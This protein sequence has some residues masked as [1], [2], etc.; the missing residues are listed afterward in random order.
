MPGEFEERHARYWAGKG[1]ASDDKA[2]FGTDCDRIMYS[3]AFRR[4]DGVTQ[5]VSSDETAMFHNRLTHSLKV[6]E[7]GARITYR[8]L[9]LMEDSRVK[10]IV[11]DH[12]G[13]DPRVVRAACL[14]HD[15]GH[16]PFGHIGEHELQRV[17]TDPATPHRLADSFEGNAQTFRIVTRLAFREPSGKI[18]SDA[19]DLTRATLRALLKYSWTKNE[20]L[21]HENEALEEKRKEKW[22]AYDSE[23]E[24]F[25]WARGEPAARH[26]NLHDELRYEYRSIEAQIMDWADDIT[27]AV[28]D[29]E[30]FFRA[31][32]IPLHLLRHSDSEFKIF[33]DRAWPRI[34]KQLG[35]AANRDDT[36]GALRNFRLSFFPQ[37]A[38]TG[39]QADRELMHHFAKHLID[40]ATQQVTVVDG[41]LLL[42]DALQMGVV[43]ALKELTWYYV[44]KRPT[45]SPIQRGQAALIRQLHVAL[46]GWVM[47][48]AG[49]FGMVANGGRHE[50]TRFPARLFD[51]LKVVFDPDLEDEQHRYTAEQKVSRAVADYIVS[52]TEA[53]A[54]ALGAQLTGQSQ[55]SM[56]EAWF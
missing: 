14:A 18:G 55:R 21:P 24:I 6:A 13:L 33:F 23:R 7:V 9:A 30:D 4:L 49:D 56:L 36:E 46:T 47:E 22:G 11:D 15:L 35:R 38:Y 52:L 26:V 34:A 10:G 25:E 31:G 29:V 48:E 45:L 5:V 28:H 43:E 32:L 12:G 41:G 3:T 42:P 40:K 54:V 50:R 51:Y 53:Q 2:Q 16:P 37:H 19:L 8:I 17:L 1:K 27:Y 39:S 20:V 44:I